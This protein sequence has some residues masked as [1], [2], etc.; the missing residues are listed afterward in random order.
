[1]A[2][3]EEYLLHTPYTEILEKV[4]SPRLYPKCLSQMRDSERSCLEEATSVFT[5]AANRKQWEPLPHLRGQTKRRCPTKIP[6]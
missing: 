2:L 4:E 3:K 6:K 5:G 1:M